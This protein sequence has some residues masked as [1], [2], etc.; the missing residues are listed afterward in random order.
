M[1]KIFTFLSV[2]AITS[3]AFSQ[4]LLVNPGF[5]NG[6]APWAAGTG[7]SYTAPE[8]LTTG[9][10]GGV[11]A[12]GYPVADATTVGAT[13]GFYQNVAISAGKTY[14]ISFW[15]KAE[16]DGTDARLWS[17][18]KDASGAPVYTTGSAADDPFRT[19]NGYLPSTAVWTKHTAEMVAGAGAVSLDVA[20]RAYGG[21]TMVHFDDFSLMDK[22]TLAVIDVKEFDKQVKMNTLVGDQ[23]TLRL[24]ERSTV[25]IYSIDGK[26]VSSN[27]VSDGDSINTTGLQKGNYIVTVDNG[28]AKISRKVIKK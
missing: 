1:K 3:T 27:R 8:I 24:P 20:V 7:S 14:V 2:L 13:T 18:Y 10:Y 25:N 22:A 21:A 12:A 5:E 16:G 26:L 6:L 15:Y 9:A 17:I 23:L 19:N 4:E 28:S 11:Q